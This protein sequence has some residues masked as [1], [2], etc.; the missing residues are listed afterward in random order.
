MVTSDADS[1]YG[2]MIWFFLAAIIVGLVIWLVSRPTKQHT[3]GEEL[4]QSTN[5]SC[6]P[7]RHDYETIDSVGYTPLPHWAAKGKEDIGDFVEVE[8]KILDIHEDKQ[9]ERTAHGPS[10]NSGPR[11]LRAALRIF[12][13]PGPMRLYL[14]RRTLEERLRI[15]RLER[16]AEALARRNRDI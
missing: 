16:E 12:A 15:A 5:A 9:L 13:N 10:T 3:R 6:P 7:A 8:A 1:A 4:R 14:R 11:V 2:L